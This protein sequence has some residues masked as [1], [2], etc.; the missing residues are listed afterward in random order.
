MD[1][2]IYN[3]FLWS[4]LDEDS[5]E[6]INELLTSNKVKGDVKVIVKVK[7]DK[8]TCLNISSDEFNLD[9]EIDMI[10]FLNN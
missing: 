1:Y 6:F 2:T 8:S 4:L 10:D 5:K 7:D 3:N 9:L